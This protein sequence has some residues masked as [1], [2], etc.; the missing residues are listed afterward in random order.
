VEDDVENVDE[1]MLARLRAAVGEP[2]CYVDVEEQV[3]AVLRLLGHKPGSWGT[4]PLFPMSAFEGRPA[5]NKPT[6]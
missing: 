4:V 6:A 2:A 1:A 5:Q 3:E